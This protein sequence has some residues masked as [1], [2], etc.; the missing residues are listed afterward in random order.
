MDGILQK[1]DGF[2][3]Q[4]KPNP[5]LERALDPDPRNRSTAKKK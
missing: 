4:D 3:L 5:K 1:I 2:S